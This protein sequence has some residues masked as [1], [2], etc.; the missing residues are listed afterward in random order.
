MDFEAFGFWFSALAGLWFLVLEPRLNWLW[1]REPPDDQP[2]QV[3]TTAPRPSFFDTL[4]GVK[5]QTAEQIDDQPQA[6]AARGWLALL[7]DAPDQV[8]HVFVVGSTGAGKTTFVRA[9][10]AHRAGD[11]CILSAKIDDFW[12][13]PF[14]TYDADGTCTSLL[15]TIDALLAH[16]RT[17]P[18]SATPLHVVIDDYP[19]L[20]AEPE[21]KKPLTELLTKVARVGRSKRM[22]LVVLAQEATAG[23]TST[24]GQHSVLNNLAR[25]DLRRYQGT[26]QHDGITYHLHTKTVPR[27]AAQGVQRLTLWHPDDAP[28]VVSVSNEG[29]DMPADTDTSIT[30]IAGMDAVS[31]DTDTEALILLAQREGWSFNRL[32][33][34][35]GGN[36]NALSERWRAIKEQG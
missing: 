28:E 30:S 34:A 6:L 11:V 22:R 1:R 32:Y 15:A 16:L 21:L 8:P 18:A 13:L 7:N 29:P 4:R 23:A 35:V 31:P 12:G 19:I 5:Y 9:L 27:L 10:L 33:R 2:E 17:R 36:R 24:Q 3:H 20:A 26:L 14:V 25:V